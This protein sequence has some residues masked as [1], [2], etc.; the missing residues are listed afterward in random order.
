MIRDYGYTHMI[1]N[2]DFSYEIRFAD[3]ICLDCSHVF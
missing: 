2:S 1:L 3:L